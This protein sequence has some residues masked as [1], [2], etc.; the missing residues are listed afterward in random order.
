M[1][2]SHQHFWKYDPKEYDW[3]G[4]GMDVLKRDFL[5]GDLE[6]EL[7]RAGFD[8]C[9][10]VQ[11][12]PSRE[13]TRW[14]LELADRN[15][16]VV[17]V[18]GWVDLCSPE[19]PFQLDGFR[20]TRLVG[21]RHVVQSE[22]DER[23][24]LREA[25]CRGIALLEERGLAYDL[26][27]YPRH[28][29]VAGEL[30]AR[31]PRQGFVLDHAAKPEIR[32]GRI[33]GWARDLR[34]LAGFPNVLCKLSG[35]VTEAAWE[36]WTPEGIRPYLDHV[37]ECF[38]P[39]RLMIGSDW[40]VCTLAAGY[41]RT[42]RLVTDYLAPRPA[43]ERE[44]ICGGNASRARRGRRKN[45]HARRR[46]GFDRRKWGFDKPCS[47]LRSFPRKRESRASISDSKRY[48][49]GPPLSRG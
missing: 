10:A 21:V 9:V 41:D 39:E 25:F 32:S 27:L 23:F 30:V 42:M 26:L 49:P 24:L 20:G 33:D 28:L 35:L 18:V 36:A 47:L 44:A 13:E 34:A 11:A 6:P 22:P 29:K 8:G 2:D 38:G 19:A 12:R 15:P 37:F 16:F 17:G 46:C 5:P 48:C 3:I 4:E 31:F 45:R 14:L 7:R 40:P 1:I 43:A